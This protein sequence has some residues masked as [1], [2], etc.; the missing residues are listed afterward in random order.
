MKQL[1]H[2]SLYLII[3]FSGAVFADDWENARAAYN[4]KDYSTA[5]AIGNPL[6]QHGDAR[7]QAL[8]AY[9]YIH[10]YLRTYM[11][12]RIAADSGDEDALALQNDVAGRLT[13]QQLVN[14]QE[15]TRKCKRRKLRDCN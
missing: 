1:A 11:W 7:A 3:M 4:R 8:L 12:S 2:I 5:L 9:L 10:G 15:I 6:A 14:A 13:P